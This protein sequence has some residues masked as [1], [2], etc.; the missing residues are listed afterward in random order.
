MSAKQ[1]I[2]AENLDLKTS[3]V[4]SILRR[5][6]DKLR[7]TLKTKTNMSQLAA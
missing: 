5:I 7:Q 2:E 1:V 6:K 4:E 3:S